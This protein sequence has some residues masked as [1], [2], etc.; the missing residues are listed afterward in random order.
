MKRT[1]LEA[2]IAGK[3]PGGAGT[4]TE[5]LERYQLRKLRETVAYARDNSPFYRHHLSPLGD[6]PVTD[7]RDFA[8]IPF[9]TASDLRR[10]GTR[11]L[12]TSQDEIERVVTLQSSG[13]TGPPKRLF[14]TGEDLETTIDFFAHGMATL[15]E[16]GR[17]VII[18]LPGT[19]RDSV[20][21]LLARALDRTNVKPV[22]WGPV[23]DAA[24][25]RTEILKHRNPCLVGIPTQILALARGDLA[26]SI[27]RGWVE[28]VLLSTDYVSGAIEEELKRLWGCR[29]LTHYGMTET[30]LGGGVEC[31]AGE[32]YHLRESDLYTEIIDPVTGV[33]LP[34]GEEGEVVF[35]TLT[36]RGMPLVRYRTG[37]RARLVTVPCPCGTP[38]KRLGRVQGRIET[39]V[40]LKE[41]RRLRMSALDEALFPIPG[42]LNFAAEVVSREG[43]DHLHLNLH[44]VAGE[45]ETVARGIL[46]ALITADTTGAFFRDKLLVLGNITFSPAEWSGTGVAKRQILDRRGLK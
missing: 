18:F 1:P 20:G 13:T 27:P 11:M 19:V 7:L 16:P 29:V 30:G 17:T 32:G 4:L 26:G 33:P 3:L 23:H 28:S 2:W 34:D 25:A 42:L 9:T 31:E 36:R 46:P 5:Q 6:N 10:E 38:L 12:C 41:G 15:V 43:S 8:S 37:D 45:E 35:T 39:E 22:I 21:D 14:F 24:A 44:T 40:L